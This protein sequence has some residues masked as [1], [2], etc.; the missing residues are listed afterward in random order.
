MNLFALLV[1]GTCTVLVVSAR[2]G[3][4]QESCCA[5]KLTKADMGQTGIGAAVQSKWLDCAAEVINAR[6]ALYAAKEIRF[7]LMALV[8]DQRI[9]LQERLAQLNE[10]LE[11]AVDE[12]SRAAY[13][14]ERFEVQDAL[15]VRQ[16]ERERWHA[17]NLRRKHNYIPFIFNVLQVLAERDELLSLVEQAKKK[18]SQTPVTNST[19]GA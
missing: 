19:A 14:R 12:D 5:W 3:S 1:L 9:A 11:G 10:Q 17:E 6:I 8:K 13:M 15:R 4:V 16:Q 7:N 2:C 18:A